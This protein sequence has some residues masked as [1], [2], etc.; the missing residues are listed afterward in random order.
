MAFSVLF[1]FRNSLKINFYLQMWRSL[2][3]FFSNRTKT[4]S[5]GKKT[6]AAFRDQGQTGKHLSTSV[7]HL[8]DEKL[9]QIIPESLVSEMHLIYGGWPLACGPQKLR[10]QKAAGSTGHLGSH[11]QVP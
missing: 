8:E 9:D 1:Y 3:H 11:G 7:S 6:T 5:D 4:R 10:A 2:R